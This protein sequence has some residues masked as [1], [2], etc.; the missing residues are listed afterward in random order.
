[1]DQAAA[2]P[3]QPDMS[4]SHKMGV[5]PTANQPQ[6]KALDTAQSRNVMAFNSLKR[7]ERRASEQRLMMQ[8]MLDGAFLPALRHALFSASSNLI[9]LLRVQPDPRDSQRV[10]IS[11]DMKRSAVRAVIHLIL[12]SLPEAEIG[13]IAPA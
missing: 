11:V 5:M 7:H 9:T 4:V 6:W 1:M 2:L 10:K 3:A 8:V 12:E 13:R